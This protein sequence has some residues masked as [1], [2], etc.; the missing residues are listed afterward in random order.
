MMVNTRTYDWKLAA[1]QA[2]RILKQ[3]INLYESAE[4]EEITKKEL[5]DQVRKLSDSFDFFID[6]LHLM[7]REDP[8]GEKDIELINILRAE[9]GKRG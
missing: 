1:L 8:E 4:S 7:D 2:R 9:P 5:K 6:I 3:I